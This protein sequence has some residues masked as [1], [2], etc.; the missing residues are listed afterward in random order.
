MVYIGTEGNGVFK[1]TDGGENWTRIVS[2][3]TTNFY[4]SA[5]CL[6]PSNPNILYLAIGGGTSTGGED[7]G[8]FYEGGIYKSTDAGESW[9]DLGLPSPTGKNRITKI[10]A[11]DSNNI[12]F[13][14][15]NF[16]DT[17]EAV[18]IQKSTNEGTSWSNI[19]T[20][21]IHVAAFDVAPLD[22]NILVISERDALNT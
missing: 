19:S 22:K 7:V 16:S 1:S 9:G 14:G 20:P 12:Y 21:D 5:I 15:T 6:D 8:T 17:T 18:G 13:L 2:G 4:A 10:M 11:W 3:L